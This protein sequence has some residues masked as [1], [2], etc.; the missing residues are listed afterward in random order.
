MYVFYR[1]QKRKTKPTLEISANLSLQSLRNGSIELFNKAINISYSKRVVYS[2]HL[3][4]IPL[5]VGLHIFIYLQVIAS[6]A[7]KIKV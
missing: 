2:L 3:P 1:F 6:Y 7:N 5:K 4:P